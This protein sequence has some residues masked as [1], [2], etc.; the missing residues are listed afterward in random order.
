MSAYTSTLP[1][2]SRSTGTDLVAWER[3]PLAKDFSPLSFWCEE[4]DKQVVEVA[5]QGARRGDLLG[6]VSADDGSESWH[7]GV[8]DRLPWP[9]M[10]MIKVAQ[11]GA[12]HW[13][14]GRVTS[15]GA[16]VRFDG[17]A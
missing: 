7:D 16:S 13:D 4:G 17:R 5:S 2:S 1:L 6:V 12:V 9:L 14:G 3:L 10:G 15:E 8:V 11:Y